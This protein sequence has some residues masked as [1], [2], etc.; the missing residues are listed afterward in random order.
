MSFS[1]EVADFMDTLGPFYEPIEDNESN[2]EGDSGIEL[3]QGN[4]NALL[5]N[6]GN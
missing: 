6:F 1:A 2:Q 3:E 4:V 5:G